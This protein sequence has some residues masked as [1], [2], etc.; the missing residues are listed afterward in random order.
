VFDPFF[1]TKPAGSGTGLGL[2]TTVGIVKSHGGFIH[3]YSEPGSGTKFQVYLP[4]DSTS[5]AADDTPQGDRT[6]PRGKGELVLVVDDDE[7][8]RAIV[9]ATL[10]RFGYRVLAAANGAEAVGLYAQ[11][12]WDVAV[13]LTDMAMPIMSGPAMI[14]ALK[15][16]NPM[17]KVIGSSGL[18]GNG[19]V[20]LAAGAGVMHF[21]PKPYTAET[22]L[23]ALQQVLATSVDQPG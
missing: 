5:V 14:V 18:A 3:L 20:E 12:R 10:E 16:I 22:L 6:L 17:L 19:N 11:R 8:I 7:A 21:V 23:T 13:V 9:Q 4:A 2:S 15:A 1:T